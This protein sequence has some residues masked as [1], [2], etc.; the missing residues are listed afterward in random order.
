MAKIG[1]IGAGSWGIAL[2]LLLYNNG[3][4]VTVWS[5]L[6][7]EIKELNENYVIPSAFD[8]RVADMVAA[9]VAEVALASGVAQKAE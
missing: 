7:E 4:K 6:P 5:A 2:S 8:P 1:M 3:H 9:K